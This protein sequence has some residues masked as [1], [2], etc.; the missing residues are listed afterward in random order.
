MKLMRVALL[1]VS[2][3]LLPGAIAASQAQTSWT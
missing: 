1:A 2:S 3:L